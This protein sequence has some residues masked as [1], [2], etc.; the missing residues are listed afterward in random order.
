MNKLKE[1]RE[2]AGISRPKLAELTGV[3]ARTLEGYEQDKKDI[4][5][6][7]LKTILKICK[8]LNCR[9]E[10]ILDDEETLEMFSEMYGGKKMK[11]YVMSISNKRGFEDEFTVLVTEDKEEAIK[12]ARDEQYIE[13]KDHN[14]NTIE[15]RVY[16]ED[17]E[18]EDCTCFDYNTIEF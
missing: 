10:D 9:I 8:A 4:N 3:S 2:E 6:A 11:Y 13:D 18:D 14:G 12:E 5:G 15:I 16:D 1:L 17:I 7:K